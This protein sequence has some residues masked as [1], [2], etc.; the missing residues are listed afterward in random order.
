[1]IEQIVTRPAVDDGDRERVML[2]GASGD[3][4]AVG[5]LLRLFDEPCGRDTYI[6]ALRALE[7]L[8]AVEA[9]DVFLAAA[10]SGSDHGARII[11]VRALVKLGFEDARVEAAAKALIRM[12]LFPFGRIPKQDE[13]PT[14]QRWMEEVKQSMA[15]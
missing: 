7:R 11:A 14:L 3:Q 2:L 15:D 9:R 8:G 1:L 5:A 12:M 6:A 4:H 13:S 10:E